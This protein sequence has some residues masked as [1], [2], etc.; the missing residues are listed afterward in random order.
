MKTRTKILTAACVAIAI[1][2]LGLAGA[3][4]AHGFKGEGRYGGHHGE[5]SEDH[6]PGHHARH[7]GEHGEYGGMGHHSGRHGARG[8]GRGM[9]RHMGRG[10]ESLFEAYDSDGNGRLTQA[11][12]DAARTDR[13]AAF[14]KDGDR[15]LTLKEYE[16]LWLDA[17][18]ERMVDRF[19]DLDNDGD[20]AVT[21]EE[22]AA[23]YAGLVARRDRNGDGEISRDDFGPRGHGMRRGRP[24][25]DD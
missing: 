17:M 2:G 10:F 4:Y 9:G 6:G 7:H 13:L 15:K 18:R 14:D 25:D 11:E 19:Q 8:M 23:P 16:A 12:V 3:S 24:D 20:A 21:A 5:Y 22:F 1:G